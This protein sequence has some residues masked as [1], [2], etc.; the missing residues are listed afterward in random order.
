MLVKYQKHLRKNIFFSFL[1]K[2][3]SS[4]NK[5]AKKYI[6]FFFLSGTHNL[7]PSSLGFY[8]SEINKT[9]FGISWNSSVLLYGTL[10]FLEYFY[11]MIYSYF[12]LFCLSRAIMYH[13]FRFSSVPSYK[14]CAFC[15]FSS[16]W[17]CPFIPV[18]F[19]KLPYFLPLSMDLYVSLAI[20]SSFSPSNFQLSYS[21]YSALID[22]N[23][24]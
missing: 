21:T 4:L 10:R 2:I 12:A 18:I 17:F 9:N 24:L 6:I 23:I 1:H 5:H 16:Y 14:K 11:E 3:T 22:F 15:Y 20:L 13:F 19:H 7:D 8:L